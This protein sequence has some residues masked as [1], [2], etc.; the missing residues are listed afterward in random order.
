[1]N[2]I[3]LNKKDLINKMP[4]EPYEGVCDLCISNYTMRPIKDRSY[5]LDVIKAVYDMITYSDTD[6]NTAYANIGSY[7]DEP[8]LVTYILKTHKIIN[9]EVLAKISSTLNNAV[10]DSV[11]NNDVNF[12]WHKP[13]PQVT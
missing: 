5:V 13:P 12:K 7:I 2:I 6:K 1:V 11:D 9:S 3:T 10:F 8:M 4:T